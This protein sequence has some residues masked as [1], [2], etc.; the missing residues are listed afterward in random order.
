[1]MLHL[2]IVSATLTL[3]EIAVMHVLLEPSISQ[4]VKHAHVIPKDLLMPH[5]TRM[6][7]VPAKKLSP[8]INVK[9]ALQNITTLPTPANPVSVAKMV[10]STKTAM[11]VENVHVNPTL[12]V[13]NVMLLYLAITILKIQKIVIATRKVLKMK[14]VMIKEDAT[15]D[16]MSKETSV[17]NVIQNIMVSQYVMPV[18][19]MNMVQWMISA[20]KLLANVHAKTISQTTNAVNV[21]KIS[22]D[23]QIAKDVPVMRKDLKTLLATL[24]ENVHANLTLLEA[25][26]TNVLKDI[27]AS[28]IAKLANVTWMDLKEKIATMMAN[29]LVRNTL[30]EPSVMNVRLVTA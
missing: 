18:S 16:V 2:D 29:A 17:M 7:F 20:M 24:L 19:V 8:V 13:T 28:Q 3:L 6:E 27:L 23:I 14:L 25:I 10:L 9:I 12:P 30:L 22:L 1:V 5:V 21:L 4:L 26:V 15:V 11:P